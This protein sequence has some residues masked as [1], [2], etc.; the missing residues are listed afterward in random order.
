MNAVNE[1]VARLRVLT[2]TNSSDAWGRDLGRQVCR[3]L[4]DGIFEN[5]RADPRV[6]VF[7]LDFTG[8]KRMDASFPQEAIVELLRKFR[9]RKY[10]VLTNLDNPIIEENMFMAFEKRNEVGIVRDSNGFRTIGMKVTP[11]LFEILKLADSQD[12]ITSRDV[13]DHFAS[14]KMSLPNAS[15]KLKSLW[16][17]GLLQR[18]EGVAKSGGRENFYSA[19]KG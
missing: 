16:E 19:V 9:G 10:F 18:T 8:L 11:D 3:Q 5:E 1:M 7:V 6:K 12:S 17:Q 15:N 2:F 13:M 14:A 4:E